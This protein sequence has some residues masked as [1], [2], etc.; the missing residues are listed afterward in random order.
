VKQAKHSDLGGAVVGNKKTLGTLNSK[1]TKYHSTWKKR[2]REKY[3]TYRRKWY[4]E[5]KERIREKQRAAGRKSYYKN[6]EKRRADGRAYTARRW[7]EDPDLMRKLNREASARWRK[8]NQRRSLE[9][10]RKS[11]LKRKFGLSVEAYDLLMK[12]QRGRCAICLGE[13]RHSRLSVDHCH[14][15]RRVRGLLC[16]SCNLAIGKFCDDV[17]RM[18]R[19]IRYLLK[20]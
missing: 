5:N 11:D 12:K 3:L 9:L 15:S 17:V 8:A 4:A 2:H 10:K 18:R 13:D 14:N 20:T 1:S 19:A 16:R 6:I 7:R